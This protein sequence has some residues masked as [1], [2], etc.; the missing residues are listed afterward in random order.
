MNNYTSE[1][2]SI[3]LV[4]YHQYD[5][6]LKIATASD[7]ILDTE[8]DIKKALRNHENERGFNLV[9]YL[10]KLD[11]K[12]NS[13]TIEK[14]YKLPR[15]KKRTYN[16]TAK[17]KSSSGK[18]EYAISLGITTNSAL[19]VKSDYISDIFNNH[20]HTNGPELIKELVKLDPQILSI[21]I[22]KKYQLK[23]GQIKIMPNRI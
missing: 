19:N 22:V 6:V 18:H 3:P 8:N 21:T 7:L 13:I 23:D 16:I 4:K 5:M 12:I 17:I 9:N 20:K 11:N 1:K 10:G 2:I 14:T 15:N